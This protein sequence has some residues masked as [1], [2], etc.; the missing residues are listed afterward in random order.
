ME[1]LKSLKHTSNEEPC[2][3]LIELLMFSQMVSE[4][5]TLHQINDEVKI[6]SIFES[7]I[8]VYQLSKNKQHIKVIYKQIGTY[9]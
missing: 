1:I 4:I 5:T 7:V 8:H 3:F 6:L 2:L 9:G